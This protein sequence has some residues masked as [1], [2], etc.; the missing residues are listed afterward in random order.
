MSSG[1]SRQRRECSRIKRDPG[2]GRRSD[3]AIESVERA[4]QS[5][6]RNGTRR[7]S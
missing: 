1:G 7:R 2:R 4:A 3:E 6:R 5:S